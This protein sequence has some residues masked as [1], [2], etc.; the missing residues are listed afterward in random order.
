[1]FR[2]AS[3]SY[4]ADHVRGLRVVD[5]TVESDPSADGGPA[6]RS[7]SSRDTG[8]PKV[9]GKGGRHR[10]FHPDP[11]PVITGPPCRPPS[12]RPPLRTLIGVYISCASSSPSPSPGAPS[13]SSRSLFVGAPRVRHVPLVRPRRRLVLGRGRRQRLGRRRRRWRGRRERRLGVLR[14]HAR[15]PDGYFRAVK[16]PAPYAPRHL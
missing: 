2:W 13:S 7:L 8:G 4:D 3:R 10:R 14:P 11:P 1:M 15:V 16:P 5:R 9:S 6:T 12:A